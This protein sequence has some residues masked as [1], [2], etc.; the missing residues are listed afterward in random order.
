MISRPLIFG[1]AWILALAGIALPLVLRARFEA[2]LR[3]NRETLCAQ[4]ERLRNLQRK[5]SAASTSSN[6]ADALSTEELSELL[7]LRGQIGL[8]HEQTNLAEKLRQENA[9]L[10]AGSKE[11]LQTPKSE[12]QFADELSADTITCM[13]NILR[14]LPSACARFA[15]DNEGKAPTDFYDLKNYLTQDGHRLTGV[16]TFEFVRGE[17]PKPGDAL[18]LRE[19]SPRSKKTNM[20]RV[21]GFAD[22]RAVDMSFPDDD[23]PGKEQIRWERAQLGLPP[24]TFEESH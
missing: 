24:P 23:G 4:A 12:S 16:Y 6:S 1:T 19:I 8:L 9:R 20:L 14:E 18:I 22:G 13:E 3:H 17:G 10:K 5:T 2:E 11:Q 15:A 21:Y 7:R